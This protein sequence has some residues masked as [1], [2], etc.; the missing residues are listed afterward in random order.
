MQ[1]LTP[2]ALARHTH[3]LYRWAPFHHCIQKHLLLLLTKQLR[4]PNGKP[5]RRLMVMTP[6]QHAKSLITSRLFPAIALAQD[7]SA[8]LILL[9]YSAEL[10]TGHGSVA[11]DY[12]REFATQLDPSG[13]LQVRTDSKAKHAW[14]TTAGGH[15]LSG[16]IQGAVTG[17]SA[18]GV[19]ID[20]P[21]KGSE[22]SGSIRIRDKV[23][24]TYNAA[25]ETRLTPDGFVCV[26]NTPWHPDDLC[27]RLLATEADQW[28]VLRFPALAHEGDI[29]GR[30]PGEGLFL[31][32]YSQQ[33]YEDKKRTY[34]LRGESH[35]W[36]ALYDCNPTGDGSLRAFPDDYFGPWMWCEELPIGERNP[37]QFRVLSLDPSKSRKGASGDY[38]AW[39]DATL[40]ADRHIYCQTHL[41]REPLPAL[42]ARAVAIVGSAKQEGRPFQRLIVESNQFQEAVGLAIQEHLQRAGLEL[43]IDLHTSPSDQSKHARIQVSLGPLL[44]Q[45]RLHFIGQTVSNKLTVQQTKELPNGAHDDGP[46]AVEMATQAINLLLTGSKRPLQPKVIRT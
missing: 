23:W 25:V 22:D 4:L 30:P 34:E 29:L 46:D 33:Y 2:L 39:C 18:T 27:G 6:P 17:R 26:I 10:A 43:P 45:K 28:M 42:Y 14:V 38:A 21:F 5:C 41:A 24:D 1:C 32:K 19:I 40:L 35:V 37:Q 16:S 20:D 15:M 12:V 11:R 36:D 8:K 3:P 31:S 13:R 44:Q 7:P 9:S